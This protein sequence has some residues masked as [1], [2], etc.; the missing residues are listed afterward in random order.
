M[1]EQIDDEKQTELKFVQSHV[2][3]L[4]GLFLLAVLLILILTIAFV[5][6]NVIIT[7]TDSYSYS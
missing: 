5:S 7:F 4:Y 6:V 2:G 3:C 1:I